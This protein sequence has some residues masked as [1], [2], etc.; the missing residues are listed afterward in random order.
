MQQ[1]ALG[2]VCLLVCRLGQCKPPQ[3]IVI[4]SSSLARNEASVASTYQHLMLSCGRHRTAT[5]QTIATMACCQHSIL[6]C[7]CIHTA[8]ACCSAVMSANDDHSTVMRGVTHG[9]CDFLIKPV[10]IEELKNI[11]QH[12]VRRSRHNATVSCRR[13]GRRLL[14]IWLGAGV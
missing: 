9:A 8:A 13:A 11:W 3:T 12:V 2:T 4:I 6:T 7:V 5:K 1:P 10:R 14:S